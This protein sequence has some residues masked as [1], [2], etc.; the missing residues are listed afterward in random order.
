MRFPV[1]PGMTKWGLAGKDDS[2]LQ[3]FGKRNQLLPNNQEKVLR[4]ITA[5]PRII[6]AELA[7]ECGLNE[8]TIFKAVR[9]L[10][11][12]GRIQRK[13]GDRGGEWIVL[14]R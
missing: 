14:K 8:N 7:A 13:G 4:L 2:S 12:G 5:N 10:R 3:P 6:T 11:E 9:K 1:K